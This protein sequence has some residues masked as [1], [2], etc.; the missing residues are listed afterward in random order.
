[1]E[2]NEK[3]RDSFQA[4]SDYVYHYAKIKP[5]TVAM[6]IKDTHITYAEMAVEIDKCAKSLMVL[7]VKK[8]DRIATL[9]PPSPDFFI[10]FLAT[11]SIGA[12]WVG[13]NPKYTFEEL[14]YVIL[15]AKPKIIF[16][17]TKIRPKNYINILTD[18]KKRCG[19][20][21]HIIA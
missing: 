3:N 17:R 14:C 8:G 4:I 9:C 19:T 13:L 20:V 18:L 11:A 5:D 15:D 7:G 16:S 1:M 10:L 12:I 6:I 21:E 2:K